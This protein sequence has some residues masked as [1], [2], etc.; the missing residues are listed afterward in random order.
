MRQGSSGL[1]GVFHNSHPWDVG[2]TKAEC[3]AYVSTAHQPAHAAPEE[4]CTC[5]LH[6]RTT[7]EGLLNE[8]PNH[9][10]S[11]RGRYGGGRYVSQYKTLILGSVLLWGV[12]LRGDLVIRAEYA[13]PIAFTTLPDKERSVPEWQEMADNV[14]NTYSVPIISFNH[15]KLFSSEF[16]DIAGE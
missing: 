2:V 10:H 12:V 8:Y 5:G 1:F 7:L 13:R 11:N 9:P 6:A 3:R 15:L 4:T 14:S 16:G